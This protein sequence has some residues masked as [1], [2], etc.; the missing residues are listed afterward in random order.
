[1]PRETLKSLGI[2]A[3]P[4]S[5][6]ELALDLWASGQDPSG[7]HLTPD[8]RR[9]RRR[10][11]QQMSQISSSPELLRVPDT[12]SPRRRISFEGE[13]IQVLSLQ[14]HVVV[15]R[16]LAENH[17]GSG[18]FGTVWKCQVPGASGGAFAYKEFRH[19]QSSKRQE[20]DAEVEATAKLRHENIVRILAR[21]VDTFT[22]NQPQGILLELCNGDMQDMLEVLHDETMPARSAWLEEVGSVFRERSGGS[23]LDGFLVCRWMVQLL[24]G[25]AYAHSIGVAHRDLKVSVSEF[26]VSR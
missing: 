6:I 24:A 10:E 5:Q 19:V 15:D 8:Q 4:L 20:L 9:I 14:D 18:S 16:N 12:D 26:Q 3:G 13:G 17:L 21:V 11:L 25:M 23:W 22:K 2:K 1:L 7:G